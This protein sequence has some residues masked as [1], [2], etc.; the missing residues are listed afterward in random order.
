MIG[1]LSS[2]VRWGADGKVPEMV[3]RQPP[4]LRQLQQQ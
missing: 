3:T 1:K 4:T 2:P